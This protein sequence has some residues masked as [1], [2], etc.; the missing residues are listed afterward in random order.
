MEEMVQTKESV[1]MV[2]ES[3]S[4]QIVAKRKKKRRIIYSAILSIVLALSALIITFS[5]VNYN[6]KPKFLNNVQGYYVNLAGGQKTYIDEDHKDYEDFIQEYESAFKTTYMTA[7]FSGKINSYDIEETNLKFY[8]NSTSKTGIHSDWSKELG[9]NYI[10]LIF[11]GQKK[12][13]TQSGKQ[14]YSKTYAQGKHPLSFE[15]CY[16]KLDATETDTMTFYLG[17]YYNETPK[18]TKVVVKAS[19][20]GIYEFLK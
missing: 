12:L 19:S 4:D 6:L 17:T 5:C 8:S 20:N 14:Y 1:D 11:N 3:V 13:L 18:L 7:L 9:S 16:L 15:H 2:L 10:E